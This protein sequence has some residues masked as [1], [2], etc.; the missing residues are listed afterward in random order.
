VPHD[1]PLPSRKGDPPKTPRARRHDANLVRIL[2]AATEM[3]AAGGFDA[4]SMT[5]LA[6][7]VDYTPGALYR[8]FAS[9]D[10]LLSKLVAQILEDIGVVLDRAVA[11]LPA[12]VS[13]LAQLFA[14]VRA[15]VAFAR[16][17]P[18]RFGL[19]AMTMAEPRV[20]LREVHDAEP[21][22]RVVLTAL[23]RLA[24]PLAAA[25]EARLVDEGD[26]SERTLCA[27]AMLQGVLQLQKQTRYAP[28]V[29]DVERLAVRGTRSLLL[30]WGAKTRAVDA[31]IARVAALGDL[32]RAL[33]A[34]R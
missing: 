21:V 2:G 33:G 22:V 12:N 3:V 34:A 26:L 20:L 4:L 23:Q 18:H 6:E 31:A 29:L 7:A 19:L 11:L 5:K 14:V 10:A 15:Y 13:P 16:L 8:Y 30:G 1:L 28:S 9:K 27:F 17:E 32:T 25:A 24:D